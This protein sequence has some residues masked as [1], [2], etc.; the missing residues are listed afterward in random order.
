MLENIGIGI[1][2][3]EIN[4]FKELDFS[5]N[6][7]FYEKNFLKSEIEYCL[8]YEDCY[9]HFA[10]KFAVKEAVKKSIKENISL[11][12]IKTNHIEIKPVVTIPKKE[13]YQFLVSLSHEKNYAIAVVISEII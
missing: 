11:I 1:D 3:V 13:K 7:S 4:R 5:K 8:K 10:A 9:R 2:I 12:D 6:H